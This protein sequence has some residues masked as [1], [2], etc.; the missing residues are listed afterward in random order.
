M[1]TNENPT[2]GGVFTFE[3]RRNGEVIDTW[4]QHNLVLDA[5]LNHILDVTFHGTTAVSPWYIGLYSNT[6][7]PLAGDLSSDLGTSYTQITTAYDE[8]TR[9]EYE[10][11][12]AAAKVTTNVLNRATFTF[13]T[14]ATVAGA[15]LISDSVKTNATGTMIAASAHSPSRSML[16]LDELL[17]KY[18][19]TGS[20]S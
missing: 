12:A 18:E 14:T 5:G 2:L 10:E 16:A 4:D 1:N 8:A 19:F 3:H 13:N 9:P 20:S 15:F 17:V 7:T 11:A 6:Y